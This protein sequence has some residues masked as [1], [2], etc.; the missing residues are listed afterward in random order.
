MT[1]GTQIRRGEVGEA[2]GEG[3]GSCRQ[4]PGL[5]MPDMVCGPY[6]ENTR[7]PSNYSK[8]EVWCLYFYKMSGVLRTY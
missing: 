6:S 1:S 2:S 8:Q 3:W 7:E 5:V 4:G